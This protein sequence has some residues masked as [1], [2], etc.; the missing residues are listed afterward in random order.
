MQIRE[1]TKPPSPQQQRVDRL[2]TQLDAARRAARQAR[3]N[4]E[5][6]RLNQQ[7]MKLREA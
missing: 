6:I 1:V 5:Q 4:H 3:L 2:K 7:R